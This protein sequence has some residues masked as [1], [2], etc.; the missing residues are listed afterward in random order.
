MIYELSFQQFS[1]VSMG[2]Y[3]FRPPHFAALF[4]LTHWK[5]PNCVS[6]LE[7]NKI[8]LSKNAHTV[9]VS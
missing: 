4:H 9:Q 1:I 6:W 8:I 2:V 7:V 3:A 5:F